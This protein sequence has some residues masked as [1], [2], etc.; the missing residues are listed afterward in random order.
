MEIINLLVSSPYITVN[1]LGHTFIVICLLIWIKISKYLYT[2]FFMRLPWCQ[3]TVTLSFVVLSLITTTNY[4]YWLKLF[5][6]KESLRLL[7]IV[8][9]T[10]LGSLNFNSL[11]HSVGVNSLYGFGE[12][13]W[14]TLIKPI[15]TVSPCGAILIT[16]PRLAF[17]WILPLF[18]SILWSIWHKIV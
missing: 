2:L 18:H 10:F 12:L 15:A 11:G 17:C 7:S 4:C 13:M 9:H 5:F 3:P 14:N 8:G 6:R 16:N 1:I